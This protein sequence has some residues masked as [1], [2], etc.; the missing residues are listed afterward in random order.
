[1]H[2]VKVRKLLTL[3]EEIFHEGGPPSAKAVP[4]WGRAG[5]D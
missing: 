4:T 2:E 1:M 5:G 3:T